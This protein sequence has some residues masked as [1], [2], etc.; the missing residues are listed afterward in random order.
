MI[1][2]AIASLKKVMAF[3]EADESLDGAKQEREHTDDVSSLT[4][5]K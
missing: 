5:S 2:C 4:P 3:D 1:E